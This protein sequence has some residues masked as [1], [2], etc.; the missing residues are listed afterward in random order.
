[1][2]NPNSS[3]SSTNSNK[4]KQKINNNGSSN[5]TSTTT[6]PCCSK[7]G[8]KRGPWTSEEDEVL[9]EYIKKEGEGRW[10]TLPKRAGLL[11]C[12]KSCRLRWMNYL[13][14]SVKRGQIAPDEEDLILRLHRLLGNRWS[15]IAGR[16]PGR[17]D[18]EIKNYWNTHLSKKLINQGIDPRTHKPLNNINPSTSSIIP[19]IN[20]QIT[21]H[22]TSSPTPHHHP[23]IYNQ[24]NHPSHDHN[25][26]YPQQQQQEAK[27]VNDDDA[28]YD[29]LI[30]DVSAMDKAAN[31]NR[32]DCDKSSTDYCCDDGFTSF[33][34]SLINDDAFA[35]HRSENDP[36]D[37]LISSAEPSAFWESPLMS[38]NFTQNKDSTKTGKLHDA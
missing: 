13:R 14:P 16:I 15:L 12:G 36:A 8:L 30:N 34:D 17:T 6:T 4:K 38:T 21:N 27:E 11:R 24:S 25:H 26:Y 7:I 28:N 1:M 37:P 19:N 29:Y 31:N 32:G 10:R 23:M 35:A 18:N 3:S 2:R 5:S 9:S 22:F 20:H 33:L